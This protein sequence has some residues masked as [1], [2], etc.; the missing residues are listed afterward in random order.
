M[1]VNF[2]NLKRLLESLKTI[3][4]FERL[5][6]W[7]RIRLQLIDANGDLQKLLARAEELIKIENLFNLEKSNG[8]NLTDTINRLYSENE[9]LKNSAVHQSKQIE[10]QQKEN[11]TLTEAN[12]NQL[13]RGIELS[14]EVAIL[15]QKLEQTERELQKVAQQNTDH[16]RFYLNL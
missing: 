14:N 9:V 2:D 15:K 5:F 13:R 12:K 7:N 8:K 16:F 1:N 6:S 4:F 11:T 3:G 10:S